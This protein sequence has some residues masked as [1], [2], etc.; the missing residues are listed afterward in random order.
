V[1][2]AASALERSIALNGG[3]PVARYRFGRI[4]QARKADAA[5]LAQFEHA[6][7]G[8]R[9]CP[10]PILGTAYLEA[11]RLYERRGQRDRA[12][13]YYHAVSSLFGAAADTRAAAARAITRIG[14]MR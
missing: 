13:G 12:L 4:E 11:A 1:P 14:V 10:P 7:R 6:I 3:D 2:A 5:A 9:T 8:A